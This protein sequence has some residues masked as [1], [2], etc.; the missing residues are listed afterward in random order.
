MRCENHDH[1]TTV[2]PCV[3][4]DRAQLRAEVAE[5]REVFGHLGTTADEAGNAIHSRQREADA[6]VAALE[7]ENRD[8]RTLLETAASWFSG[9]GEKQRAKYIRAALEGAAAGGGVVITEPAIPAPPSFDEWHARECPARCDGATWTADREYWSE[10]DE[11]Q[12]KRF[13]G[14][15]CRE[16]FAAESGPQGSGAGRRHFHDCRQDVSC[17][18]EG[19]ECQCYCHDESAPEPRGEAEAHGMPPHAFVE[20]AGSGGAK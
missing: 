14:R 10:R 18:T 15:T 12:R 9:D 2:G 19:C 8:W 13:A 7:G 3:Y 5:W 20:P 4:C 17:I 11:P 16:V 1:D 6:R